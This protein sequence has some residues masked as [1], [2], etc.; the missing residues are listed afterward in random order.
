M[1]RS[2]WVPSGSAYRL[3]RVLGRPCAVQ[4]GSG[5][6][7]QVGDLDDGHANVPKPAAQFLLF[8]GEWGRSRLPAEL[9]AGGDCRGESFPGC[10][11]A[12]ELAGVDQALSDLAEEVAVEPPVRG[13]GL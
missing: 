5:D 13:I 3:S 9:A 11:G 2:V 1:R 4:L 6:P 10:L 12:L 7:D 8:L